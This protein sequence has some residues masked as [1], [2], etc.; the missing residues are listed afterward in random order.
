[1]GFRSIVGGDPRSWFACTFFSC[2][3]HGGAHDMEGSEFSSNFDEPSKGVDLVV[4]DVVSVNFSPGSSKGAVD[5]VVDG[6][7]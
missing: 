1:M 5:V 3:R 7:S 4:L 6:K 2:N